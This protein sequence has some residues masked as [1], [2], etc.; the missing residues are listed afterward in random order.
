MKGRVR[1][2]DGGNYK[3]ERE[4]RLK[5][6]RGKKDGKKHGRNTSRGDIEEREKGEKEDIE[7][8]EGTGI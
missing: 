2:I 5:I 3:E 6:Q 8:G 1:M 4:R 7:S